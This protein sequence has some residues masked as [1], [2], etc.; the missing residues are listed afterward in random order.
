MLSSKNIKKKNNNIFGFALVNRCVTLIT[1]IEKEINWMSVFA[2]SNKNKSKTF[3]IPLSLALFSWRCC[4]LNNWVLLYCSKGFVHDSEPKIHD[5]VIDPIVTNFTIEKNQ[6]WTGKGT[7]WQTNGKYFNTSF[8]AISHLILG[9]VC[10]V[11]IYSEQIENWP[12]DHWTIWVGMVCT[13]AKHCLLWIFVTL[14]FSFGASTRKHGKWISELRVV[15]IFVCLMVCLIFSYSNIALHKY[16]ENVYSVLPP[17]R[18]QR[19]WQRWWRWRFIRH[20]VWI[21]SS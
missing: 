6:W 21:N 16:N 1:T 17:H 7:I 2:E 4:C 12:V 3:S 13:Y 18:H 5:H 8:Q 9:R 10:C 19:R 14:P 20:T 15:S 11:Y